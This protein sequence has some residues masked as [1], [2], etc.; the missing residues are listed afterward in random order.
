MTA[1]TITLVETGESYR[2]TDRKS[3]LD[4]M[5]ALGKRGIPV[6]CRNG[7]CG[8]CKV[9]LLRGEV[10]KRVM[11][12]AHVTEE[13]EAAGAL[14]A[15]RI[16]PASDLELTVLGGMKKNVC[17]PVSSPAPLPS[18]SHRPPQPGQTPQPT[19]G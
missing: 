13:E 14:L 16:Q 5:A 9:Q 18:P 15:C 7:G 12:R 2:C 8:V 6:G 11:S 1:H 17:R 19:P 4:G 10:T 3:V